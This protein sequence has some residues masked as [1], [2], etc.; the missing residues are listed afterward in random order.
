MDKLEAE[1]NAAA[2]II[3]GCP[4]PTSRAKLLWEARLTPIVDLMRLDAVTAFEL[5]RRHT[6][7]PGKAA[8]GY[9]SAS[10]TLNNWLSAAQRLSSEAHK[11]FRRP[12]V[13]MAD[14]QRHLPVDPWYW[15][16]VLPR[17]SITATIPGIRRSD[18]EP[19]DEK[20]LLL[21]E[22][23]LQRLP[24][25]EW[26]AY[27]DGSVQGKSGGAGVVLYKLPRCENPTAPSP[28][29]PAPAQAA[30]KPK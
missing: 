18:P 14:M 23:A 1:H 4:L 28:T 8:C 2:R 10:L 19:D 13:H 9:T 21:T 5:F 11:E 12:G 22:E 17:L 26:H 29:G 7:T 15:S 16:D 27:T 3:T 25:C 30:F 20:F 24:P 6:D